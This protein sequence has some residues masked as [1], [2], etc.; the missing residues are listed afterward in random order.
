MLPTTTAAASEAASTNSGQATWMEVAPYLDEA[1]ASLGTTDRHA[2]LLRFFERKE[3][4]EVGGAMGATEGAAKKRVGRALE[5][6]R[7]FLCRRGV[8]LS[9]ASLA[10]LLTANAMP[11]IPP[12]I[13]ASITTTLAGANITAS[14]TLVALTMK[15][16]YYAKLRS[17][18]AIA[19]LLLVAGG[20]GTFIAV[21]WADSRP[22]P[23]QPEASVPV[24]Q[25]LPAP[26]PIPAPAIP[27]APPN[28]LAWDAEQKEYKA[29]PGEMVAPFTFVFT[30]TSAGDIVINRV[31]PS[32]GCTTAK[33]LPALPWRVPA[34][35]TAQ[36]DL[37]VNLTGKSGTLTK[38]VLIDTSAG[39]K[40]LILRVQIPPNAS[41][42]NGAFTVRTEA[43]R[44]ANM[45][46]ASADQQAI[47]KGD[48]AKC[49]VTPAVGK[50]GHELYA[51]ACGICHDA[52][53]RASMVPDL[54]ILPHP[55]NAEFWKTMI[56]DGK[57]G[58]AQDLFAH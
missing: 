50:V 5:K 29:G 28:S 18:A 14:T 1:I 54:K 25:P 41:A 12:A 33:D 31:Q 19:A 17:A 36:I 37:V 42:T 40:S 13:L 45:Q 22:A 30:N 52:E 49:H 10:T 35:A 51:A 27:P 7:A 6:I 26:K 47:F 38:S 11:A 16:M 24:P 43:E 39:T 58:T 23:T 4:R 32:C 46:L 9:A 44:A 48:C 56:A 15:A 20:A 21:S 3:M 2:I 53:H 57:P 34:S 8:V 55:T